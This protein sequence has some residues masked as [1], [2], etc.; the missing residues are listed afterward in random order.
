[1][2]LS[3]FFIGCKN[4]NRSDA[5]LFSDVDTEELIKTLK[6]VER[7]NYEPAK[8]SFNEIEATK[9]LFLSE[10]VDSVWYLKLDNTTEAILGGIDKI[11]LTDT[12]LF[13]LDRYKTKSIKKFSLNGEYILDIG[14]P[15]K[16]PGEFIEPTDFIYIDNK[17]IV[18]DQFAN[19]LLHF[20]LEGRLTKTNKAPFRFHSFFAFNENEFVY[21]SFDS[22]NTHFVEIHNYSLIWSDSIFNIKHRGIFTPDEKYHPRINKG[23]INSYGGLRFIKPYSDTIYSVHAN[24]KIFP[25]YVI[26]FKHHSMPENQKQN[27]RNQSRYALLHECFNTDSTFYFTFSLNNLLYHC[28]YSKI[29]K[30][31]NYF[32]T[33]LNDISPFSFENIL[34]NY[35]NNTII[36]YNNAHS[37]IERYNMVKSSNHIEMINTYRD[38]RDVKLEDN[39]ILTFYRLKN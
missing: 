13:I 31:F 20:T 23:L 19:N 1:M 16:G 17:L 10:V 30:T 28:F 6:D 9:K 14:N 22:D 36:G 21:Q 5:I 24:G 3:L 39:I 32:N 7:A 29:K 4:S 18:F 37:I 27:I 26:D 15:G 8:I 2:T 34:L 33:Q 11:I 38:L 12:H 35:S 25:E